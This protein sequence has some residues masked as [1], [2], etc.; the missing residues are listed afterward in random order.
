MS[1]IHDPV[2]LPEVIHWLDPKAPCTYIDATCGLGGHSEAI[3]EASAPDG[4]LFAVDRDPAAIQLAQARLQRFGDRAQIVEGSFGDLAA[5]VEAHAVPPA[6]GLLADLGVSSLQ[7]DDPDRGFSFSGDAD[8][9]MRMGPSLP[10]TAAELLST[11][12]VE[13]LGLLLRDLGEVRHHRAVARAIIERR[14]A[15]NLHRTRDLVEA[16]ERGSRGPRRKIHPATLV[17]QAIRIAV[18]RELDQLDTLLST[19]P[20]LLAQDG[21]AAIIS[22]HSLEDRRVKQ[23][24]KD[25]PPPDYPRNLPVEPPRQR[26]PFEALTSKPITPSAEEIAKN[27]RARS[28]KLRVAS[29]RR[30]PS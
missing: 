4:R 14:D 1:A 19:L 3:L 2:L 30:S 29:L 24:F 27:P 26:G 8:L 23:A 9:D 20:S 10:A 15:G 12:D 28:A 16:V 17:F 18:N 13:A 11:I 7:L 5:L 25:P 22:F 6:D 21:R